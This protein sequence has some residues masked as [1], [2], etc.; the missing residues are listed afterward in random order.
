MLFSLLQGL[1]SK[2]Y[3]W[4]EEVKDKKK[5]GSLWAFLNFF[6]KRQKFNAK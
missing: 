1:T 3:L 6:Y 5:L 4:K 2:F